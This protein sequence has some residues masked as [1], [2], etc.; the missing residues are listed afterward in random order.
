MYAQS[1]RIRSSAADT[2]ARRAERSHD[3]PSMCGQLLRVRSSAADTIARRAERSHDAP[4]DV[5]TVTAGT[6][7]RRGYH[8]VPRRRALWRSLDVRT[9]A[10]DMVVRR[11]PSPRSPKASLRQ[12]PAERRLSLGRCN[13][14]EKWILREITH[15]A[16]GFHDETGRG[17]PSK[18]AVAET[19]AFSI[20]VIRI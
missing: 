9:V 17:R 11:V 3:A 19:T 15:S 1:P 13:R 12:E 16:R 4:R 14:P 20:F 18:N 7:V 6:V 2:I 5:R 8:R 10:A